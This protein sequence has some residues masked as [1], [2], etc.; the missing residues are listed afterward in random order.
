MQINIFILKKKFKGKQNTRIEEIPEICEQMES[1]SNEIQSSC[2]IK[3]TNKETVRAAYTQNFKLLKSLLTSENTLSTFFE[4]WGPERS[5]NSI[6]LIFKNNDKKAFKELISAIKSTKP[7]Y[8]FS[9]L[10]NFS[11][12]QVDTGFN[13]KYAYGVK[14]RRVAAG[15][16]G[17]EG[18]NALV[19]DRNSEQHFSMNSLEKLVE[20]CNNIEMFDMLRAS[21]PELANNLDSHIATCV[22]AG[23]YKLAGYLI[24]DLFK[25]GGYGYNKLHE[26]VLTLDDPTKLT[27]FKR[28][29]TMK[30]TLGDKIITPIH[31]AAINP[32]PDIL[33]SLLDSSSEFSV[34]DEKQRKPVHYAATCQ[35]DGP[36]R[37]LISCGVDTREGDQTKTTPLMLACMHNRVDNVKALLENESRANVSAKNRFGYAA[38]HFAAEAGSKEIIELLIDNNVDINTPGPMRMTPLIIA[39]TQG[40]F[41][42]VELLLEKG[43]KVLA[44]D[45]F[46]RS[47][48]IMA[49]KNGNLKV[50]ALLLQKGS[51]FNDPDSSKNYPLHYAAAYGFPECVE[52][53][54]KAGAGLNSTNSWNLTPLTVAM[55]KNHFG[56]VKK[57]LS[58]AETDVNC[59]DDA[60][61][62]LVSL[63]LD[64]IN[65]NTYEH[66]V[67]LVTEK[68]IFVFK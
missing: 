2:C 42:C 53:L 67:F 19:Y 36:L 11:M 44:K 6:E 40:Y 50:A 65:Q 12:K 66:L 20:T 35:T 33:K 5:M 25:R 68:V 10:P 17:K 3:C 32:N 55:Q 13:D 30:K 34:P 48:L 4:R 24:T 38:I 21:F 56:I 52:L 61:R 22:R 16:G 45:K 18:N 63:S 26:E 41:D 64:T 9:Y 60:G 46:K 37:L 39:S 29:S 47:A 14:T 59:K 8:K 49:V 62:T 1:K 57:L 54:I 15:R 51:N 7:D 43:A 27:P 23:N 28:V 58:Y 31:C